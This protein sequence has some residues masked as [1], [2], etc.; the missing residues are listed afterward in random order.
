MTGLNLPG[1]KPDARTIGPQRSKSDLTSWRLYSW[2]FAGGVYGKLGL[3]SFEGVGV[4]DR[5]DC[6]VEAIYRFGR[7]I[8]RHEDAKPFS[9]FQRRISGLPNR[10]HIG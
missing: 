6:C 8:R 5:A 7:R 3:G 10:R 1:V 4:H 2:R 9:R